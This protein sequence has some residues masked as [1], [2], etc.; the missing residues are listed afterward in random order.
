MLG[1][2]NGTRSPGRPARRWSDDISDW[3]GCSLPEAVHLALDR[4]KLNARIK[5]ITAINGS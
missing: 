5:E 3:F 4:D 1:M 2:I